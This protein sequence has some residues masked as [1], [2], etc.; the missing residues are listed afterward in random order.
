[1]KLVNLTPHP[2]VLMVEGGSVEIPPSGLVARAKEKKELVGILGDK[3]T[4]IPL[5]RILYGEL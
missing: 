4:S 2:I 1:M 5:Y 3:D